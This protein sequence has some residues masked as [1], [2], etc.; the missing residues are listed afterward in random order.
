M[1][2]EPGCPFG[3]ATRQTPCSKLGG[4][5]Q[6]SLKCASHKPPI[7][8]TSPSVCPVAPTFFVIFLFREAAAAAVAETKQLELV[9]AARAV[10]TKRGS[11]MVVVVGYFI[12][13]D[14]NRSARV[15]ILC[16]LLRTE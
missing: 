15:I 14:C 12:L 13:V 4:I 16:L 10:M 5:I 9:A 1:H 6:L 8:M 7:G 2:G 3:H 11:F